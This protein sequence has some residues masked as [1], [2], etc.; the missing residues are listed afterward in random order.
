MINYLQVAR[1]VKKD[2]H[3]RLEQNSKDFLKEIEQLDGMSCIF[4]RSLLKA[5]RISATK[6]FLGLSY[7]KQRPAYYVNAKRL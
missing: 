6:H 2:V 3:S 4:I 5:F 1:W 7:N